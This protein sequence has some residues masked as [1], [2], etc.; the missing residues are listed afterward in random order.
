[1]FDGFWSKVERTE[2]CW[3]WKAGTDSGGYGHIFAFGQQEQAHRV[4]YAITY[5]EIPEGMNVQHECDNPPC[6]RP[7]HLFLGTQADN[8]AD[9]W[10]KGRGVLPIGVVPFGECHPHHKLE[11]NEVIAI[12]DRYKEGN[13][14]Q[15]SLAAE[16][17][18]SRGQISKIVLGHNW[19]HLLTQ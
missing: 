1:M 19:K 10:A 14:P 17:R 3:L 15:R 12:R 18:I 2:T 4:S 9:M 7:D 16:Y 11:E 5:G 8:T 6:V 13:V